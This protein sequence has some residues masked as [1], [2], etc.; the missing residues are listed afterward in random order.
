MNEHSDYVFDDGLLSRLDGT[1][2]QLYIPY[3][4]D[5][6]ETLLRE[7]HD[8]RLERRHLRR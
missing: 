1:R 6:R 2:R 5:L 8:A 4:D 3:A 7:Y